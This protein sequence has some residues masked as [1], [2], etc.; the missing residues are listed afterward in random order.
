[1]YL[2]CLVFLIQGALEQVEIFCKSFALLFPK[3]ASFTV[4]AVF[5][6]GRDWFA[7]VFRTL[8]SIVFIAVVQSS[9]VPVSLTSSANSPVSFLVGSEMIA[10]YPKPHLPLL[11]RECPPV[12]VWAIEVPH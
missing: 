8:N 10:S 9:S 1:M 2:I 12:H 5:S 7:P 6:G 11:Q 3:A 4:S